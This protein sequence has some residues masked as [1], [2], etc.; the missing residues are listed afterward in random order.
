MK[1]KSNFYI[2]IIIVLVLLLISLTFAYA[3]SLGQKSNAVPSYPTISLSSPT[4]YSTPVYLPSTPVPTKKIDTVSLN[5]GPVSWLSFPLA[6]KIN[7][8][9][10]SSGSNYYPTISSAM[11]TATF[12]D[13]S[14]LI[15]AIIAPDG[16]GAPSVS[17]YLIS[18]SGQTFYLSS[19][20]SIDPY[21]I[22]GLR[23]D[24]KISDLKIDGIN[25]P[26]TISTAK[27]NFVK[28]GFFMNDTISFTQVKNPQF[29][30]DSDYG[31]FYVTY[32]PRKS[33][34]VI[35]QRQFWLRLK[36]DTVLPYDIKTSFITDD[37][38]PNVI[39]TSGIKNTQ[40]YN[41]GFRGGCGQSDGKVIKK[42]TLLTGLL[43][44]GS[45]STTEDVF[46]ISD[47]NSPIVNAIYDSL[48]QSS[49][50]D[51]NTFLGQP[52]HFL[53][54]DPIGD[55]VVFISQLNQ[56]QA[57][58]GKP[59][60]YLYPPKDQVVSVK[61]GAS[62]TKSEPIYPQNGWTVLAHPNGQL[63]YQGQSYPN[64]F[65]EGTGFGIYPNKQNYGF[66]VPQSKLID[67]LKS[68]LT[69][70]G[71]NTQESKDFMDFWTDKLP[72]TPHVRLTWLDTTDMN[73]L[74]PLQIFPVP[75]TTIRLFLD[76][77]GLDRP[78]KLIPQKLTAPA[79]NG[80]TLVEW[81]GLL[82]K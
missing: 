79:R 57:E 10:E 61:V 11:Q 55:W 21:F 6:T 76:F 64:L 80:F 63:D 53:W 16:P 19:Y 37:Q 72:H 5:P 67:T 13:G 48:D 66:I 73:Q 65:W 46:L 42:G 34:P 78:I 26:D 47:S 31:R 56:I 29:L 51:Y 60:I 82:R 18:P 59:V 15:N 20:N 28:I 17:R 81:G 14:K 27:G 9:P 24:I 22:N 74:A 69:Q 50:P 36:D 49:R 7:I 70:L 68:Q 43:K 23:S 2:V 77:A 75:K 3:Y 35:S 62:I 45:T 25:S 8:Y 41:V 4:P 38:V 58:C 40:V 1:K 33:L 12:A 30:V 52:N 32:E 54:L 39:W 44:A 71:L